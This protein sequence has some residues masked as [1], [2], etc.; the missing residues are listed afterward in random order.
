MVLIFRKVDNQVQV[1]KGDVNSHLLYVVRWL[2]CALRQA[3]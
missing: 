1:S 2:L 3:S